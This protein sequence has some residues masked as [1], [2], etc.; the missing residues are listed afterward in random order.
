MNIIYTIT[1]NVFFRLPVGLEDVSKF[2]DLLAELLRRGYTEGDVKKI[3]G[4]NLIRV[5]R[6]VE[7][8]GGWTVQSTCVITG[9]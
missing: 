7:Q 4:Q 3:A 8:V 2:P 9:R 5:F 6:E 1:L